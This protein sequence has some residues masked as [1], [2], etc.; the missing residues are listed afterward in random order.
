V[1]HILLGGPFGRRS[2]VRWTSV[3]LVAG[4]PL[5]S[6]WRWMIA[7]SRRGAKP[8]K[9]KA[10]SRWPPLTKTVYIYPEFTV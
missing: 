8:Q 3:I 9:N 5:N 6:A 7:S 4:K 2:I 1:D 10:L